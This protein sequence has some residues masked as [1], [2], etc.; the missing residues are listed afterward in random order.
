[1]LLEGELAALGGMALRK[2]SLWNVNGMSQDDWRKF[3]RS[4]RVLQ[5]A[6]RAL[7]MTRDFRLEIRSCNIYD[8]PMLLPGLA[9]SK[10]EM[11]YTHNT[12]AGWK[13]FVHAMKKMQSTGSSTPQLELC[14][15]GSC[16]GA[17]ELRELAGISL[18]RLNL[19]S[20]TGTTTTDVAE[21]MASARQLQDEATMPLG[22][23]LL[24]KH[25]C[26]WNIQHWREALGNG[27]PSF[28]SI[29]CHVD[30]VSMWDFSRLVAR[31]LGTQGYPITRLH[32]NSTPEL[33][34]VLTLVAAFLRSPSATERSRGGPDD[35]G[36]AILLSED[37]QGRYPEAWETLNL[38]SI[39]TTR[40]VDKDTIDSYLLRGI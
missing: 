35:Q 18:R 25:D 38:N 32:V 40:W 21:F 39:E 33:F 3:V 4:A 2:L 31:K 24:V 1:M 36:F 30:E 19:V 11:I 17:G 28:Q 15:E 23:K 13:K 34:T 5:Q 14:I 9:L 16:W 20:V 7:T 10:L 12:I 26:G 27:G 37:L 8:L 29:D 6:D 22:F